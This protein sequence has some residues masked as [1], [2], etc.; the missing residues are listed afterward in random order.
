[1]AYEVIRVTSFFGMVETEVE[2]T[3]E[4]REEAQSHVDKAIQQ[5]KNLGMSV[6]QFKIKEIN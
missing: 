1:M 6:S 4:T 3:Y 5:E 2:A